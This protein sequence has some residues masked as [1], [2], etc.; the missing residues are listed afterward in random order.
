[1]HIN[2]IFLQLIQAKMADMYTTL[3]ACRSYI[4]GIA[5][6]TANANLTNKVTA[7]FQTNF[8]A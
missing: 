1:M 7:L 4:Y 5:R 3:C 2:H 8:N 6:S